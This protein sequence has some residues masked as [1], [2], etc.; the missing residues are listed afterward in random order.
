MNTSQVAEAVR[1]YFTKGGEYVH[2]GFISG[3][4]YGSVHKLRR[5]V[6]SYRT[7]QSDGP[8]SQEGRR[9]RVAVKLILGYPEYDEVSDEDIGEAE[10]LDKWSKALHVVRLLGSEKFEEEKP[11]YGI[12]EYIVMEYLEGGTIAQCKTRVAAWGKPLTNR[13]LWRIFRCFT[14]IM[15]AMLYSEWLSDGEVRV[16][17]MEDGPRPDFILW[18]SDLHSGNL[19]FDQFNDLAEEWEHRITP[20]LKMIDLGAVT[21]KPIDTYVMGHPLFFEGYL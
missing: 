14:R 8:S 20:I 19:M 12:K 16:E 5:Q 6:S 7:P 10:A 13:L 4:A 18:N 15:M 9:D 2:E 17:E 3:G 1:H 11:L 21:E